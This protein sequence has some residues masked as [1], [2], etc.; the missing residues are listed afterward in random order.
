MTTAVRR[1]EVPDIVGYRL[2]WFVDRNVPRAIQAGYEFVQADEVSLNQLNVGTDKSLSGNADLG[3]QV[4][5]VAGTAENGG[6]E[7]LTL[8]KIRQEWWDEDRKVLESR[9]ADVLSGIFRNEA[10]MGSENV[11]G[12]DRDVRYV[13]TALLQR[14][15]RKGK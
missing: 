14:P 7:H 2:Y 9:N 11:A 8:M 6:V 3:N 4:R 1:L 15:T 13:K 12:P 10:I 5:V